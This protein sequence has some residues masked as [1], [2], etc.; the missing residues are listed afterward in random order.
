M[1]KLENQTSPS[2]SLFKENKILDKSKPSQQTTNKII[3][4][5]KKIIARITALFS[6][7]EKYHYTGLI[8]AFN[9]NSQW[10][11]AQLNTLH[12]QEG[13]S[14][15]QTIL[16]NDQ[17]NSPNL[18][19]CFNAL[20]QQLNQLSLFQQTLSKS[21]K[22]R[23]FEEFSNDFIKQ[24]QSLK[25]G[26]QRLIL[27]NAEKGNEVY[28][29]FTKELEGLTIKMIGR[30]NA[31]T[32]L[33]GIEEVS[34]RGKAKIKSTVTYQN[35]PDSIGQ[36]QAWLKAFLAQTS[37]GQGFEP[38][39]INK[40]TAALE[41]YKLVDDTLDQLQTKT[42]NF[43]KTFWTALKQVKKLD[44]TQDHRLMLKT[45]TALLFK[46]YQDSIDTLKIDTPEYESMENMAREVSEK[47][48]QAYKKGYINQNDLAALVKEI[49]V[50][51][52]FLTSL[53][54]DRKPSLL[55]LKFDMSCYKFKPIEAK[56]PETINLD[57]EE[58]VEK[59]FEQREPIQEPTTPF[60]KLQFKDSNKITDVN[61]AKETLE[62]LAKNPSLGFIVET[63]QNLEFS[64]FV[65]NKEPVFMG[66]ME[67]NFDPNPDSIWR[68]L[69]PQE[70][71]TIMDQINVLSEWLV[72]EIK[73]E[74][75]IPITTYETLL[76][77][78]AIV[79]FLS[80]TLQK[81]P[82]SSYDYQN[83][84]DNFNAL[85]NIKERWGFSLF[86]YEE[87]AIDRTG[88]RLNHFN[89]T[90]L[91]EMSN[92]NHAF[93]WE[94]DASL[95]A[96]DWKK[97]TQLIK[98]ID[99][100]HSINPKYHGKA[101]FMPS[102]MEKWMKPIKHPLLL[103]AYR[104]TLIRSGEH[105]KSSGSGIFGSEHSKEEEEDIKEK[106]NQH[107]ARK[108]GMKTQEAIVEEP[109][110]VSNFL[111]EDLQKMI[112]Y[113]V[114]HHYMKDEV[115]P[116][117]LKQYR[118][119]VIKALLLLLRWNEPQIEMTG[120][121]D[122]YS[123]LLSDPEIRNF[124]DAL[125]FEHSLYETLYYNH[126]DHYEEF[127]GTYFKDKIEKLAL[128]IIEKPKQALLDQ[129]L[130][131]IEMNQKL[132][133]VY[134]G[135]NYSTDKFYKEGP[136]I[137][138]TLLAKLKESHPS[139]HNYL[140]YHLHHQLEQDELKDVSKELCDYFLYKNLSGNPY[141]Q[142]PQTD[143]SI[144]M[145]HEQL[146]S[147][148]EKQNY[149][150]SHYEYV[151]D[152]ICAKKN[153]PL[154]QSKWEGNFP[155]FK[156]DQYE[157]NLKKGTLKELNKTSSFSKL[158][159]KVLFDPLFEKSFKKPVNVRLYE[160][161]G[162]Q[163]YSFEDANGCPCRVV[164]KSGKLHYYK[165]I[166]GKE[167]QATPFIPEGQQLPYIFDQGFFI[168]P[169]K[170]RRGYCVDEKGKVLFKVEMDGSKINGI[171]DCR[172]DEPTK[173]LQVLSAKDLKHPVFE[174]I[175]QIEDLSQVLV[176][177]DNRI[178]LPRYN[179]TFEIVGKDFICTSPAYKGYQIDLNSTLKD[180]L[181]LPVSLLLRH[182]DKELP[183]KLILPESSQLKVELVYD[184]IIEPPKKNITRSHF[185]NVI[186]AYKRLFLLPYHFLQAYF[187]RDA[188]TRPEPKMQIAKGKKNVTYFAV[189]LRPYTHEIIYK[190]D[191]KIEHAIEIA[192]QA[193]KIGK[194]EFAQ[195][196]VE[197][198]HLK[199]K[200]LTPDNIT[201]LIDFA[202]I[203]SSGTPV[204]AALKLKL[205]FQ[206]KNLISK[207]AQYNTL[208]IG[209]HK[210]MH[211]LTKNYL[212]GHSTI[213]L[214][215]S[216]FKQCAK[217]VK[218]YDPSYFNSHL[219]PYFIE[220]DQVFKFPLKLKRVEP[221]QPVL[222]PKIKLKDYD[223][224][225]TIAEAHVKNRG[226]IYSFE[227]FNPYAIDVEQCT[228]HFLPIYQ[229][230][231]KKD[232]NDPE[233]QKIRW[234]LEL[235]TPPNK[236]AKDLSEFLFHVLN[237]IRL[238]K[239]NNISL[240]ALPAAPAIEKKKDETY[241]NPYDYTDPIENHLKEVLEKIE[242]L[243]KQLDIKEI[244][245]AKI[246]EV[247][248]YEGELLP[249][250]VKKEFDFFSAI[251]ELETEIS[252]E[253]PLD[254]K[255][256]IQEFEYQ[257]KGTLLLFTEKE[258]DGFFK[259][260]KIEL[261]EFEL[262][263]IP[264]DMPTCE[265]EALKTLKK[266][267]DA[268]KQKEQ[269]QV[270]YSLHTSTEKLQKM[271][272]QKI[273]M[274]NVEKTKAKQHLDL[275]ISTSSD[276]QDQ[277]AIYSKIKH[278]AKDEDL[279]LALL[280]DDLASLKDKLPVDIDTK[281]LKEAVLTYYNFEVR[282]RLAEI[283]LER[284]A[285][286]KGNKDPE[287]LKNESTL[288]HQLLTRTQNYS[289]EKNPG[290]LLFEAF[291]FMTYR[292]LNNHTHQLQ[293]LQNVLNS[294]TGTTLAVTGAGKT[295]VLSILRGL[296][297]ANGKNLVTQKVLPTLYKQT[298]Q[299]MQELL[300]DNFKT[301]LYPFRFDLKMRLS[302][303][304][305]VNVI[306]DGK[307]EVEVRNH[308]IFKRYYLEMLETIQNKG[309]IVTDYKSFPLLEEK[310]WKLTREIQAM[311]KEG[312]E[313]S[314]LE[315]E[316]WTYLRKILILHANKEDE[317][318]DEFDQPNRPIHRIQTQMDKAK[319][320][321]QFLIDEA[322]NIA[323][324]LRKEEKLL[325]EENL[326]GEVSESVRLE[327]LERVADKVAEQLVKKGVNKKDILA[328]LLAQ[329][330]DVCA[331]AEAAW[332]PRELDVLAYC[333]D[334]FCTY[335]PLTLSYSRNGRYIR[336]GNRTEPAFNGEP[337]NAKFGN[338][339]EEINY[340]IQDSI[341]AGVTP[342][343]LKEWIGRLKEELEQGH[344]SAKERFNVI[345]EDKS[346]EEVDSYSI[347]DLVKE[348]NSNYE[349]IVYFL[350]LRL[351]KL[352]LSGS[353][354]SMDPQNIVSMSRVVS[355]V[356]A[357]LG[358]MDA[359]HKQFNIDKEA[360]GQIQAEMIFRLIKRL[361]GHR[362]LLEYDPQDPQQVLEEA[363]KITDICAIIDGAN[364]YKKFE[365]KQMA[366]ALKNANSNLD[367]VG[368]YDQ[369]GNRDFVGEMHTPL[370]KRGFYF[371]LSKTRGA[372][373]QLKLDGCALLTV[374]DTG[375]ME[376]LNQQEGRMR[377]SGQKIMIA[378][379]KFAPHIKGI[380]EVVQS[381]TAY[382]AKKQ[383]NDLFRAK[384]QELLNIVR[385][386]AKKKLLEI[387]DLDSNL[388]KF[389]E[390]SDLFITPA[391]PNFEEEG[392]YYALNKHIRRCDQE[393][394]IVLK[395]MKEKLKTQAENLGLD[396]AIKELESIEYSEELLKLMP[397]KVHSLKNNVETELEVEL[398][399]EEEVEAETEM[400][401]ANDLEFEQENEQILKTG[402]EIPFYLPRLKT[403]VVHK[404]RE[405][406]HPAYHRK[407]SFT[408]SFL[409]LTRK[410]PM[411]KR[412]PFDTKM[413]SIGTLLIPL[414]ENNKSLSILLSDNNNWAKYDAMREEEKKN[415][416]IPQK[417]IIGDVLDFFH[418][419]DLKAFFTYDIR[420]KKV[421]KFSNYV[422]KD[423][424]TETVAKIVDSEEFL[425]QI[426]QIR[427]LDGQ[428]ENYSEEEILV[429]K[430]WIQKN[431]VKE[432]RTHFE[433]E[434]LKNRSKENYPFSQIWKL[435]E[436][437][438]Q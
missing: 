358:C 94:E 56:I 273:Q 211:N 244:S 172:S 72:N 200:D 255:D 331:K 284:I 224:K 60:P 365:P 250:T 91:T 23:F 308:S 76:K 187:K 343:E 420:S 415:P 242:D 5:I 237:T 390:L 289:P 169:T 90:F 345:F 395:K 167:L 295:K 330:E 293:L 48:Y 39:V 88:A 325:L 206:L 264:E 146:S 100:I 106:H 424:T 229:V 283:C 83:V 155:V 353:V 231:L 131:F 305:K 2:I 286:L 225:K 150:V 266:N 50:I 391:S 294:P 33:S 228:S 115:L 354:I 304:V 130:F 9:R 66:L 334:Q 406:I 74:K 117:N 216:E 422:Y 342:T 238:C 212:Q 208:R 432:M 177:S 128:K 75:S 44:K 340:H 311:K 180:R 349:H 427:F 80:S 392:S 388:E 30:G 402:V 275:L 433:S 65:R 215:D 107:L 405:K 425:K 160:K 321:A 19:D 3:R 276:P 382:E 116:K 280:R 322:I 136:E 370:Q 373:E 431:G 236:E 279:M 6:T 11:Q 383:S 36:N 245:Q 42:T 52:K 191:Q 220:E 257:E 176:W 227:N 201:K 249:K 92:F 232:K 137:V 183:A 174:K 307:E 337:M 182:Q 195:K 31:M 199:K 93:K 112:D 164:E 103:A 119:E 156:N 265:Q 178:E 87:Q 369:E 104:N 302:E 132:I 138:E 139:Y 64:L 278:I 310:Y 69:T 374:N 218:K 436:E 46:F 222:K 437:L 163:I 380:E 85:F 45:E 35:I 381:K 17:A 152:T 233:F 188:L 316:H 401:N 125:F 393:P 400:E 268:F 240:E 291:T 221:V 41:T 418:D 387:D 126:K 351:E 205:C 287:I 419:N 203:S 22:L 179:L 38:S 196:H 297:K 62:K 318:M 8:A 145:H 379:S 360:A 410:D 28:Y 306:K 37:I 397:E 407:I 372:D 324:L 70:S 332:T 292:K 194:F 261:P 159:S 217:Y 140:T 120:F 314:E 260:E 101:F 165:T 272:S 438:A 350:K 162:V 98:Q 118:P 43:V 429:L 326:Q 166:N 288:I 96:E 26:Q 109:E 202:R 153:L 7:I 247:P 77:M 348:V 317:M 14:F 148:L 262:P 346:L 416:Y 434:V 161:E 396:E 435:F 204:E 210:L 336:N 154:D 61:T 127:F 20:K 129:L 27:A 363:Q 328:Y 281:K 414:K 347:E 417:I 335:F 413:F 329:N 113:H 377:L 121:M 13:I 55:N 1:N 71:V 133:G 430:D 408:D 299:I 197:S 95:T 386:H 290:L 271:L 389:E 285:H 190:N 403:K 239:E 248:P 282:I 214:T 367:R 58:K 338:I 73:N 252:P 181:D 16:K 97:N 82:P 49:G 366:E 207:N 40:L 251:K 428:L 421:T 175:S 213:T 323:G 259:K 409:P 171:I 359:Y 399:E 122:K 21:K 108:C 34:V 168:D 341:Q 141:N 327:C 301:A 364:A 376:D 254:L 344:E 277:A 226:Q 243:R 89:T 186:E 47:A 57:A 12:F 356:S 114:S 123:H 173:Q 15:I 246:E 319:K 142:D 124:I 81:L 398:E 309:C 102:R 362:S 192:S 352:S 184:Q 144:E 149:D 209:L 385:T 384:K 157:I 339:I 320:P 312:I 111:I 315:L 143:Y 223:D 134:E 357:T 151:L 32:S 355:G 423:L 394:K 361:N 68:K 219:F 333:K 135:L 258:V 78:S 269:T 412:E 426:A 253:V 170:P 99:L 368:F 270:I 300:G 256:F 53:Q 105:S 303:A 59:E 79:L 274:F 375:T 18:T 296:L 198:I 263:T 230:L 378:R 63:I 267:L 241:S 110:I 84:K 189:D 4:Y 86:N 313:V 147:V 371:P 29:L 54:P 67:K 24:L 158:P 411:Y 193:F 51:K 298:L 185:Q 234:T 404:A 25:T 10:Q 235:M